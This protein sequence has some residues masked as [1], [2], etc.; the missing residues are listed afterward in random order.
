MDSVG[1]LWYWYLVDLADMTTFGN[2]LFVIL[3]DY[4]TFNIINETLQLYSTEDVNV[5]KTEEIL[6]H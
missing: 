3:R 6:L 4:R 1:I 2:T 5:I